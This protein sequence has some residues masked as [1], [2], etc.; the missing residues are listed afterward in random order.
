MSINQ[1][2]GSDKETIGALLPAL[3]F[4]AAQMRA[5]SSWLIS[6][7]GYKEF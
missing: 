5:G 4:G 1:F 3:G 6:S 7:D 2:S